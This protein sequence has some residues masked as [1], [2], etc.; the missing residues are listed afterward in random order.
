MLWCFSLISN[1]KI[2]FS[3]NSQKQVSTLFKTMM[4][5][6]HMQIIIIAQ[7]PITAL[8]WIDQSHSYCDKCFIKGLD[9]S[10]WQDCGKWSDIGGRCGR[11]VR[12]I[13][14]SWWPWWQ[15][16]VAHRSL[17]LCWPV[18]AFNWCFILIKSQQTKNICVSDKTTLPRKWHHFYSFW[19]VGWFQICFFDFKLKQ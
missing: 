9:K 5:W 12:Q 14:P 18:L 1:I 4:C 15:A 2:P 19:G 6:F 11:C 8:L 7:I 17:C 16:A 3:K 10:W 13:K